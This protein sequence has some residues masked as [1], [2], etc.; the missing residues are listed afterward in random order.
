MNRLARLLLPMIAS[1]SLFAMTA[2]A[3]AETFGRTTVGAT[4][5]GGVRSEYKRGSKFTLSQ[6]GQISEICGYVDGNGG[7]S[8]AQK[9]RYALY[10]DAGGV[11]G[12]KV[13]AT[14]E[15]DITQG[16]GAQWLCL[17]TGFMPLAPGSYWLMLHSSSPAGVMRFYYDGT[18]NFYGNPDPFENG[19]ADAFG[20]GAPGDGTLSLYA[21]YTP[22]TRLR[23]AGRTTVGSEARTAAYDFIRGSSFV[24][25]EQARLDTLT[26]YMGDTGHGF[27][28]NDLDW[29]LYKDENGKPK[30]VAYRGGSPL[31]LVPLDEH[32]DSDL[33]APRW[34]NAPAAP[35]ILQPGRYWFEI[36]TSVLFDE[37]VSG[38]QLQYYADGKGNWFGG[39]DPQTFPYDTFTSSGA[40]GDG[41]ISA[42]ITYEPGPFVAR[43]FGRTSVATKAVATLAEDFVH[44]SRFTLPDDG[45]SI[46][47]VHVYLDGRGGGTGQQWFRAAIFNDVGSKELV[48]FSGGIASVNAGDPP[49]WVT[50]D[51]ARPV[52]LPKGNYWVGI[53]SGFTTNVARIYGDGAANELSRPRQD[54][55]AGPADYLDPP[56]AP[57]QRGNSTLSIY[58]DYMVPQK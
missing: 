23:T 37:S 11:P 15:V 29:T 32:Y 53:Q 14:E 22:S 58:V 39:P 36:F 27:V 51:M 38:G 3:Q 6:A 54:K 16:M 42:F 40:P 18:K 46:T 9:L 4:A 30:T 44:A 21:R 2:E 7:A 24:L 34:L 17:E 28:F 8:G 50:L 52:A 25:T 26:A 5:S 12:A 55:T 31:P 49:G 43:K 20:A 10:R 57:A 41:T 56:E 48:G 47:A 35:V 1:A 19:A 33:F 45:A 13:V